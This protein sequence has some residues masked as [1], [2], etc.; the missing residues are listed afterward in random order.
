[1]EIRNFNTFQT[2]FL[3]RY[4]KHKCNISRQKSSN[5]TWVLRIINTKITTSHVTKLDMKWN[6]KWYIF[7]KIGW[8]CECLFFHCVSTKCGTLNIKQIICEIDWFFNCFLDIYN[9]SNLIKTFKDYYLVV[10]TYL[11]VNQFNYWRWYL[12]SGSI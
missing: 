2:T 8:L 12:F 10:H 1:M 4:F 9:I 11:V 6:M 7:K 3:M 5:Q